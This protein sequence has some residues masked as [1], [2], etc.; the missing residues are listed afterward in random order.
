MRGARAGSALAFGTLLLALAACGSSPA[1]RP[2]AGPTTP[3]PSTAPTATGSS[4]AEPTV[5][6]ADPEHAVEPPGPVQTPLE[7]AD[8]LLVDPDGGIDP[9]LARRVQALKGVTA[10]TELG[11]VQVSIEN[12][13]YTV[14][15]VEPAQY[16]RFTVAGSAT[17]QEQWERVAGGELAVSQSLKGRLPVDGDGYL[18][19]GSGQ[20]D[21]R[22][23]VGAWAPQVPTVDLVVNA[24]WGEELGLTGPNALLVSARRSTPQA[25]AGPIK[26]L[27]GG[28]IPAQNLDVASRRGLDPT[29]F[30]SAVVVGTLSDAI[31]VYRYRSIGGGRIA[32]DEGW[33]AS[34]ITTETVPILGAVTCN[35]AIFPQLKAA[36]AEVVTRGLADQIH[37]DEYAG[38]YYP[39]FIAG[40]TQLSNHAFGLALDLN[41][42]GNQRG[43]VGEMNREV[44]AIFKQW[45]FGWGGD[46]RYTDPMHFELREIRHPG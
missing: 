12:K 3:A 13:V 26:Q 22:V 17:L 27:V 38:C 6:V 23:H 45:G 10:V 42:P 32:P 40:T 19:L 46:W 44:V 11:V 31:G 2:G 39:R 16:R 28:E 9:D 18:R 1:D 15:V 37:R 21:P 33:V 8:V 7:Q 5:P 20:D 24:A 34:H 30:Q 41:V 36:L 14:A 43:T 4:T 25:L 29:V 35:R